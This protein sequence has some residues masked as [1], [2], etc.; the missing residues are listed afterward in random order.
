MIVKSFLT[1]VLLLCQPAEAQDIGNFDPLVVDDLSAPKSVATIKDPTGQAPTT[2]V[3]SFEIPDAYCNNKP[4]DKGSKDS[5]CTWK[6]T[7]SQIRENVFATKRNGTAQPKQSWYGWHVYFPAD[8]VYGQQ[9]TKG[10]YEFA[11]WHNH[12]CPHLTFQ[13]S[14][15]RDNNL[16]L[17][18]NRALGNYECE[19]GP[20]L[21]VADFKD[22]VGKWT[23]FE[24]FVNWANDD[25]GKA[26]IYLDSTLAADYAGP[27]LTKGYEKIN[28][29][30]FG[31]YLCCTDDVAK[32]KGTNLYFAGVM[33]ANT[34][35]GLGV[36]K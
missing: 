19:P 28:Y 9:Q 7:R 4:Y 2:R 16:Y 35:E 17:Q 23:K 20:K 5:D 27:T 13:N 29:F 36:K 6:S 14:A 8:F 32:I 24:V 22:L 12:Q 21:K 26:Q 34:R 15:G 1:G 30:K 10:N 25:T 31:I 33:R 18:T 3:Y 11:Y